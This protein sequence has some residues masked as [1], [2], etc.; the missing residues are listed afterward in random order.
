MSLL[1][2][3]LSLDVIYFTFRLFQPLLSFL[4]HPSSSIF[5]FQCRVP[6]STQTSSP[7]RSMSFTAS[8][9]LCPRDFCFFL[10]SD[11]LL[12]MMDFALTPPISSSYSHP[13]LPAAVWLPLLSLFTITKKKTNICFN[14]FITLEIKQLISSI[15]LLPIRISYFLLLFKALKA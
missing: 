11:L 14:Y 9:L 15:I 7:Y 8:A 6:P 13:L 5:L 2:I 1:I 12:L 10:F 4:T 3:H